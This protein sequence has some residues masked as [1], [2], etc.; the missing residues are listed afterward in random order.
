MR[1]IAVI[2][3]IVMAMCAITE[4]INKGMTWVVLRNVAT[5]VGY[6]MVEVGCNACDR[7]NGD[8][9]CNTELPILCYSRNDFKRPPYTYDLAPWSGGYITVT[10]VTIQG[11][12]I[13]GIPH[14]DELCKKYLGE[15]F[16]AVYDGLGSSVNGMSSTQYFFSTWPSLSSGLRQAGSKST[17]GYGQIKVTGHFWVF[18]QDAYGN[19]WNR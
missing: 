6:S 9:P 14:A 7:K 18:N 4:A 1:N 15:E 10:P 11:A 19:C 5:Q 2:L 8:T 12:L 16:S 13:K 3:A 17:F